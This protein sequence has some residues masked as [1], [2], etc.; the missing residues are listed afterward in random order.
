MAEAESLKP[1]AH[2]LVDPLPD[3]ASW[4]VRQDIDAGLQDAHAGRLVAHD[5]AVRRLHRPAL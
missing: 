1:A 5:E 2:E 3:D 4:E